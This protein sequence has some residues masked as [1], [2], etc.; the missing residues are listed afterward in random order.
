MD[1][2]PQLE[3]LLMKGKGGG[4]KQRR[5]LELNPAHEIFIKLNER[6]NKNRGDS[7]IETCAEL[8]LGY[9]M[10]A[11]GSELP[12]PIKFNRLL[13]NIALRAL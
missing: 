10:L 2:S 9:A 11:E 8:M 7:A 1:Y 12:D 6:F 5:I 13:V 3:R 4:P